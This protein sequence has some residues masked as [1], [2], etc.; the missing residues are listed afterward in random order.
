MRAWTKHPH[1]RWQVASVHFK[2]FNLQTVNLISRNDTLRKV[3]L[4]NFLLKNYLSPPFRNS[5]QLG[6]Y[7]IQTINPSRP[8][9]RGW[10]ATGGWWQIKVA[11]FLP[12]NS[13]LSSHHHH[14]KWNSK[15]A[16]A[17]GTHSRQQRSLDQKSEIPCSTDF[18][19]E[20][21]Q[22]YSDIE[23]SLTSRGS[24]YPCIYIL[25]SVILHSKFGNLVG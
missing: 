6:K 9:I 23:K 2:T 24:L 21:R 12:I 4:S 1:R 11:R 10:R 5:A 17:A 3:K 16:L 14:R 22:F 13:C 25:H 18:H 7:K 15:F 19:N 8:R 20:M